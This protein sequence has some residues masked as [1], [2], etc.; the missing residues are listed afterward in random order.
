MKWS[1]LKKSIEEKFADPLKG[2]VNIYATRYT[3][4]SHYMVRGW[5]TLDGEEIANFST[6]DNNNKYGWNTPAINERIPAGERTAGI[7]AEKGEFSRMEFTDACMEFLNLNIDD[8]FK[9]DNPII[10]SLAVLDRRSGKRRLRNICR[11]SLHPLT[12]QL[13][14]F[15]LKCENENETGN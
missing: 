12:L 7:A 2:R 9:S 3:S 10:R 13:L 5:I 8:A 4:G 15:R 14:E 6:P 1:R 11:E